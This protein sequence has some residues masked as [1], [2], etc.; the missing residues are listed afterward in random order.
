M[1]VLQFTFISVHIKVNY[2]YRFRTISCASIEF[3]IGHECYINL[4]VRNMKYN[5]YN[6]VKLSLEL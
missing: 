1:L 4:A 3:S 6:I 5:V 2:S